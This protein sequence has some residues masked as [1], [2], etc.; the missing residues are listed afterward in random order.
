MKKMMKVKR[1]SLIVFILSFT[2]TT[3]WAQETLSLSQ[4]LE[5]A[6]L[7][8]K[9]LKMSENEMAI[10]SE[11]NKEVKSNLI[12][13]IQASG[14]YKYFFDLPTQLMPAKAF[15]PMAPEW[16]FK[17]A[18]FG[19]PHNINAS[20][21]VMVPVYNPQLYGNIK[22][23]KIAK[24]LSALKYKKT[25]E[26]IFYDLSNLYYNAQIIKSQNK[27]IEGNI[28]NTE[29]LLKNLK[30]LHQY[31]MNKQS[32]VDKI[33]LQL[34][35]LKTMRSKAKANFDQVLDAMKFYMGIALD[36]KIDVEETIDTS[37]NN[38]MYAKEGT[39]DFKM[40]RTKSALIQSEISTLKRSRLPSLSLIGS[41][42]TTGYGYDEKP[43]DF[44][45]FY[46]ISF[47]GAKLTVPIFNGTTT[48]H[49]IKQKQFEL[50]NSQMQQELVADKK[51][52]EIKSA[53]L[54]KAIS[55]QNIEN[56]KEQVALA[57]RIYDQTIVEQK[58]GTAGLADVIMAD[59]TLRQ[60]QQDY[61]QA[62]ID[63]LKADLELKKITGNIK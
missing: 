42:G 43:H 1:I 50:E 61:L 62:E 51:A 55:K 11:K 56:L 16:E 5:K 39:L 52:M 33:D 18:Q 4:V 54:Q 10:A 44:L 30:L 36:T 37:D 22:T 58:Q 47:V 24:E 48:T 15:N 35:Q 12:P 19:V 34:Q 41:Y 29:K 49:K 63:Y 32:D 21:Q 8:N 38:Y 45:D 3:S 28:V 59:N 23:T 14:D 6:K 40:A 27:F 13:K 31:D 53:T 60:A 20:V 26:Q 2:I 9:T 7:Y 57:Q 17:P 46:D 25:K